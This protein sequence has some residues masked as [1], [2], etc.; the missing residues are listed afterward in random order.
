MYVKT[1]NYNTRGLNRSGGGGG[2]CGMSRNLGFGIASP[3]YFNKLL[4]Q[5]IPRLQGVHNFVHRGGGG[6]G[7]GDYNCMYW[8]NLDPALKCSNVCE[9]HATLTPPPPPRQIIRCASDSG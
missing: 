9:L 5:Y 3:E 7:W 6:G 2:R 8:T 1:F 4:L